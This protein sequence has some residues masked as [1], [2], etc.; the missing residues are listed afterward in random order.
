[1]DASI[2]IGSIRGIRLGI[3]YSWFIVLIVFSYLLSEGQFPNQF[4]GWTRTQ[5]W[6]V[7]VATVILLFA[8]VL[9]HELAHSVVAQTRGIEV[10]GITLFIF[11][12][13]AQLS[14]DSDEPGEEFA[15]AI[16]GPLA[17]L[18][19]AGL[20][21]GLWYLLRDSNEQLGALL[22]YLAVVNTILAVFN[23]IPGF[24]LDGGRVLRAI[25]WKI[26]GNVRRATRIVS[27]IGTLVGT[28]F[29]M[30][31]IISALSGNLINGL[32]YIALS[33]FMQ[34]AA[35]GGYRD[36]EL[37]E[38]LSGHVVS[39]VMDAA[40]VV[41]RSGLSVSELVDDWFLA[42][43]LRGAPVVTNDWFEGIVTIS[44][45][46]TIP[47]EQWDQTVVRAIMTPRERVYS[48]APTDSVETALRLLS[49]HDVDQLPVL[50]DGQL[51]G[52]L[53][54]SSLV[55]FVHLQQALGSQEARRIPAASGG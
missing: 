34:N 6:V 55:R 21:G 35:Q 2:G 33:W 42:R 7:G 17:S 49:E 10:V 37:R 16:A 9:V 22:G 18:G 15:I 38:L 3:H 45:V 51:V 39:E 26:T 28:L 46:R 11:G 40:P 20:F 30:L 8:S 14:E 50:D 31:G 25:L 19:L 53:R 54:R 47:R 52:L 5:Y 27:V 44:D 48:V 36:V 23:L 41:V 43:N 29:F 12:G 32:W 13:V 4:E 1:M 24:P